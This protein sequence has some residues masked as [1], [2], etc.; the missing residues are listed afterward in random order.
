[1]SE[2]GLWKGGPGNSWLSFFKLWVQAWQHTLGL[3]SSRDTVKVVQMSLATPPNPD[4]KHSDAAVEK[5]VIC[6]CVRSPR[7][8]VC[9]TECAFGSLYVMTLN[10]STQH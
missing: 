10:E 8:M 2:I 1:M 6:E 4:L 9:V 7:A 5:G 3:F